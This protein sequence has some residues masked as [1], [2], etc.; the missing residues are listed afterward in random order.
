MVGH[1]LKNESSLV[2]VQKAVKSK[3]MASIEKTLQ[4]MVFHKISAF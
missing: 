1:R 4:L 3:F 2:F